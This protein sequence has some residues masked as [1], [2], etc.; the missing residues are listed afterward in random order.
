MLGVESAALHEGD[1]I[2]GAKP[3]C[4]CQLVL[5]KQ[6]LQKLLRYKTVAQRTSSACLELRFAGWQLFVVADGDTPSEKCRLC[7]ADPLHRRKAV[8]CEFPISFRRLHR[9][10]GGVLE[11]A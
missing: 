10:L 6:L 2:A 7:T 11:I 9:G 4:V 5:I 1:F 3:R 8:L